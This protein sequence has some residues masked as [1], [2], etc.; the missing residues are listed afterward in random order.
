VA[1]CWGFTVATI[2]QALGGVSADLNPAITL[3]CM[4]AGKIPV[5]KAGMYI[6]M[7][8]LGALAGVSLLKAVTP[9][10]IEG[11]WGITKLAPGVTPIQGC[12]IEIIS[13][14]MLCFTVFSVN[15]ENR[16]EVKG[17]V[18]LAVGICVAAVVMCSGPLTGASLN[19]A[20]S[21]GP[22]IVSGN[23]EDHWVY[24]I[25]PILGAVAAGLI[26]T[27]VF[28]ALRPDEVEALEGEQ[29]LRQREREAKDNVGSPAV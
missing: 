18:P 5:V 23:F 17:S 20:R 15:D 26:Y 24:W 25:G 14:F 7:Q 22:S 11:E 28:R 9:D 29:Q 27:H 19:P 4:V 8:C 2:A 12:V 6:L 13:T 10:S 21:L 3:S 16:N 1:L